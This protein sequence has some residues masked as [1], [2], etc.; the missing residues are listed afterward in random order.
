MIVPS[1]SIALVRIYEK[2]VNDILLF[3]RCHWCIELLA[4]HSVLNSVYL[5]V[6]DVVSVN[7]FMATG[8]N[9]S[10]SPVV[11]CTCLNLCYQFDSLEKLYGNVS[12][13]D[14]RHRHRYEVNPTYIDAFEKAGMKFVGRSDDNERMEI[15]ELESK[16]ATLLSR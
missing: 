4:L 6:D 1:V 14:E 13:V 16:L 10:F 3:D 7:P 12:S 11:W 15:L 2:E 9:E 8:R 5:S